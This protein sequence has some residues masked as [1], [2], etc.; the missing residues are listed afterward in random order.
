MRG[1]GVVGLQL[2]VP[3]SLELASRL[4]TH[5]NAGITINPRARAPSGDRA[6]L[7]ALNAGASI[8]LLLNSRINLMLES[9]VQDAAAVTGPG[10]TERSTSFLLNPGVR[11]AYNFRS[12]LQIVP[13]IAYTIGIG[14]ASSLSGLMLYLSFEHPF[15]RR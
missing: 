6:T 7:I 3:V 15:Q 4:A 13:G 1:N 12:G 9:V 5:F 8:I 10:R 2:S 14:D 11:W